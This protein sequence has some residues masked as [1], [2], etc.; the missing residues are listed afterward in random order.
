[1]NTSSMSL[2]L[3]SLLAILIVMSHAATSNDNNAVIL[4]KTTRAPFVVCRYCNN[5]ILDL[6]I[7][8]FFA[9]EDDPLVQWLEATIGSASE[10][11][12]AA[13]V[14]NVWEPVQMALGSVR[15]WMAAGIH[16]ALAE[17]MILV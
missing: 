10:A 13:I 7:P 17:D 6:G 3:L 11:N 1:M 15:N 2:L 4:L 12:R 8:G 5:E 9:T 14:F 16:Q